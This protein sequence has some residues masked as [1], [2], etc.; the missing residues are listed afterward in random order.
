MLGKH[1]AEL[2]T[3]S[4]RKSYQYY[5]H[6]YYCSCYCAR[7]WGCGQGTHLCQ[8]CTPALSCTPIHTAHLFKHM[9]Y[10]DLGQKS[11]YSN[12]MKKR[13]RTCIPLHSLLGLS[14]FAPHWLLIP[15][16]GHLGHF[17]ITSVSATLGAYYIKIHP[18]S[19]PVIQRITFGRFQVFM[20]GALDYHLQ[21]VLRAWTA[22][23]YSEVVIFLI[24]EATHPCGVEGNL[25][26]CK[27]YKM[28][29]N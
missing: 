18:S 7:C 26:V 27:G 28:V 21:S 22:S 15:S 2:H 24:E 13:E 5:Y 14:L 8:A 11:P 16:S 20:D 29:Y 9:C 19:M 17:H 23:S 4:K 12:M 3:Q 1:S 10:I 25:G 6:H